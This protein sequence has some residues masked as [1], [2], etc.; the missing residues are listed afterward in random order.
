[1]KIK[2]NIILANGSFPNIPNKQQKKPRGIE[3]GYSIGWLRTQMC[4]TE[5]WKLKSMV[6]NLRVRLRQC[7][8]ER[9]LLPGYT[10]ESLSDCLKIL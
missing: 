10:N 2:A 4:F 8:N 7:Q 6:S 3:E 9:N 5:Q 1:M